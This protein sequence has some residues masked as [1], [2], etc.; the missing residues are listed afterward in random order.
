[1]VLRLGVYW[2]F[3]LIFYILSYYLWETIFSTRKKQLSSFNEN[4][5]ES[6]QGSDFDDND[7]DNSPVMLRM[8]Q[9]QAYRSAA[10]LQI[11]VEELTLEVTKV[12][13]FS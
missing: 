13:D 5:P 2:L 6:F 1:L 4:S 7:F 10:A 8:R 9:E 12:S 11:R 3:I